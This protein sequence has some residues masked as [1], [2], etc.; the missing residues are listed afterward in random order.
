MWLAKFALLRLSPPSQ[1]GDT[2]PA[3]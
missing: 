3:R 1:S 2:A